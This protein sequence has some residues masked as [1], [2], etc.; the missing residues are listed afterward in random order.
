MGFD[1][2]KMNV[3]LGYMIV[4]FLEKLKIVFKLRRLFG[5]VFIFR[6]RFY[7]G[8]DGRDLIYNN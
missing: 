1:V 2:L 7:I 5:V 4:Q 8:I 6:E 3:L